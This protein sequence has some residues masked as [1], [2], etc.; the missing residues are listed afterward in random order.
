MSNAES[1]MSDPVG[2]EEGV[3]L[4]QDAWRRLSRNWLAMVG[5]AILV[6]VIVASLTAP[7]LTRY[8]VEEQD[9][10]L[11]AVAPSKAHWS[12]RRGGRLM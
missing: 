7:W 4:W 5:M 3:S 6:L 1:M 12:W 10:L 11:G 2:M 9:V 8:T